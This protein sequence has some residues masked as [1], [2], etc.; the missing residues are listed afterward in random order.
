MVQSNTAIPKTI[1]WLIAIPCLTI[2]TAYLLWQQPQ[3]IRLLNP[4]DLSTL[5]NDGGPLLY[6]AII[7][8][9]VVISQIPG[10]PLAVAAGAVWDPL[11]AGIYTIIGG[12]SGALIAYGLG[13]TMGQ[14]II[15]LLTGKTLKVAADQR[16]LGWMIL[17]TRLLPVFSFDLVSYGAGVAGISLPVYASATF[18]GMVPS[19][20]LL[21]YLGGSLQLSTGVMV[22]MAIIFGLVFVGV[23][24]ILHRYNLLTAIADLEEESIG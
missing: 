18:F 5:M 21:T 16:Y 15:T 6:I 9:S 17:V 12:F 24:T 14:S 19:T 2:A 1:A 23:P 10:A 3:V 20:L 22:T 8:L 13:K 7:A 11:L 4:H